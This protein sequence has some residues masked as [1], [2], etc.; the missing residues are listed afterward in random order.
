MA[1]RPDQTNPPGPNGK[2]PKQPNNRLRLALLVAGLSLYIFFLAS[3]LLGRL[4]GPPRVELPCAV[5]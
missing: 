1:L 2:T 4:G 3:P 5:P